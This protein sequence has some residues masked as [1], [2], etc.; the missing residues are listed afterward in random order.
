MYIFNIFLTY[1][2]RYDVIIDGSDNVATRYLVNDAC[3]IA[4]KPLVSGC[5]VR[6]EGQLTVYNYKGGPCYRCLYPTPPPPESV[7]DCVSGGVLGVVPG[8]IGTLQAL[9]A[10]KILM[11]CESGVLSQRL[12]IFHGLNGSI[13][14]VKVRGRLKTCAVCGDNPTIT[15]LVAYPNISCSVVNDLS[16]KNRISVC[17]YKKVL[18]EKCDHVLVDVRE[19][20][21]YEIC[22]F[23]NAL[24]KWGKKKL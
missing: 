24:S 10:M 1:T 4:K 8:V 11:G 23:P 20:H 18:D 14:T 21:Q 6:L 15:K 13:R 7:T 5:A 3:V 16:V 12:L 9:E 22:S 19:P 17:D 2:I